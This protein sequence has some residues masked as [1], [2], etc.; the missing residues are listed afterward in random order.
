MK[1]LV[2]TESEK[3]RI[4]GM[5]SNP[6]LKGRL[7]EQDTT[8]RYCTIKGKS[9]QVKPEFLEFGKGTAY[10][11]RAA[12]EGVGTDEGKVKT[13]I[14]KINSQDAYNAALWAIQNGM[15]DGTK[16]PLIIDYIQ[17]EFRKPDNYRNAGGIPGYENIDSNVDDLKYISG[18]LTKYNGDE[19]FKT[20][21]QYDSY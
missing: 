2:I 6:S 18:I 5:H 19:Q 9:V 15:G 12:M 1:R 7:F 17:T 4:L 16:H 21:E 20:S 11:L 14:G 3:Q 8:P 13:T 10:E